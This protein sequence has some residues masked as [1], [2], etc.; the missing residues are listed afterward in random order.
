MRALLKRGILYVRDEIAGLNQYL[1]ITDMIG[2]A[3]LAAATDP[4]I[5]KERIFDIVRTRWEAL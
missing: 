2:Q 3:A 5:D 1:H 4:N